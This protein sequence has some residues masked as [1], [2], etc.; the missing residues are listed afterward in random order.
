MKDNINWD[1]LEKHEK[2]MLS[3]YLREYKGFCEEMASV[4][5]SN[6]ACTCCGRTGYVP[7][8]HR[9][10]C[11]F[12]WVHPGMDGEP[13]TVCHLHS[14]DGDDGSRR[15]YAP[16]EGDNQDLFR[17]PVGIEGEEHPPDGH[18]VYTITYDLA[19]MTEEEIHNLV[20][21][22]QA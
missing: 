13:T 14:L 8:H 15:M 12:C 5:F 4:R 3:D 16:G 1:N 22:Y 9:Y 6:R 18:V 11:V 17:Y 21:S 7:E 2:Q 19:S 20:P 10:L